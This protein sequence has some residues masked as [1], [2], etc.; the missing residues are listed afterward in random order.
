ME[1]K[2]DIAYFSVPMNIYPRILYIAKGKDKRRAIQ[3][4]FTDRNLNDLIFDED[5]DACTWEVIE[6]NSNTH[7]F[8]KH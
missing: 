2:N 6:R 4:N 5:T 1:Q 8:L 7:G 3:N